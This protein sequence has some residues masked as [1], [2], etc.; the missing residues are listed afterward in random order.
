MRNLCKR[1]DMLE[2][3]NRVLR[4][5]LRRKTQVDTASK[6]TARK[7]IV[8]DGFYSDSGKLMAEYGGPGGK[9]APRRHKKEFA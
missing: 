4:N 5:V 1:N 8:R 7:S 9:A 2:A 3:R 6:E